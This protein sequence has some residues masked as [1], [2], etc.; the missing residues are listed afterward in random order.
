MNQNSTNQ[1]SINIAVSKPAKSIIWMVATIWANIIIVFLIAVLAVILLGQILGETQL[2][3]FLGFIIIM[4]SLIYAVRLGVQ[5]V[6]KASVMPQEQIFNIALGVGLVNFVLGTGL[7]L[8]AN[9]LLLPAEVGMPLIAW[10]SPLIMALVY[11][12]VTYY[13]CK[14]LT[15]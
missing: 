11:F 5:S 4:S 14:K 13:W 15:S 3:G 8:F 9:A 1:E 6:L 2:S 7:L 10:V 12:G